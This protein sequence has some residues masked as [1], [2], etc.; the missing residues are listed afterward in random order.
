MRGIIR[1]IAL[2]AA[3][4]A[5]LGAGAPPT[6]PALRQPVRPWTLDYGETACTAYRLYG[7]PAAPV[8]FAL[9]PSP[10][11]KVVRLVV[12]FPGHEAAA[13]QYEVRTNLGGAAARTTALRFGVSKPAQLVFVWINVARADLEPL[14]RAG[15]IELGGDG[16]EDRFALPG[17]GAVLDS[18]D[19]CNADLRA[20]WHV[21]TE[22]ARPAAPKRRLAA[23][24]EPGDYP[25][26]SLWQEATGS[27]LVMMMI[28]ET[29]ALRDCLVEQTSGVAALDAM[30]CK[31][32]QDRAQFRPALDAAGKPVK[33]VL[34]QSVTWGLEP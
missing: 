16:I 6:P 4:A 8:T 28:D 2:A 13:R 5:L 27:S 26:Q 23:Y 24:F 20:Y 31:I 1:G 29:G 25:D 18:L 30:T 9:R 33:S 21:G 14:R 19:T 32:L 7:D 3:G 17:I 34:S 15:A 10:T 11:G 22:P 12:A